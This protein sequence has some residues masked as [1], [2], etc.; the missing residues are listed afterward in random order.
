MVRE[1]QFGSLINWLRPEVVIRADVDTYV[2][3]IAAQQGL[4]D[5][6]KRMTDVQQQREIG[7][8][9]QR[10]HCER[11]HISDHSTTCAF[12]QYID[13]LAR[14]MLLTAFGY[15]LRQSVPAST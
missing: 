15:S 7:V 2:G 11:L 1:L 5:D 10:S 14:E 13:E 4:G 9:P 6:T 3:G 8:L 12:V